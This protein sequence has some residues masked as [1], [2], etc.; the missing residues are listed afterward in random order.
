MSTE[1]TA[2]QAGKTV[3]KSQRVIKNRQEM[4]LEVVKALEQ[5]GIAVDEQEATPKFTCFGELAPEIRS[6]IWQ[7]AMP[8]PRIILIVHDEG[9]RSGVV[10]HEST[11]RRAKAVDASV[12]T[13][14]QVN[15][16]SR[17]EA[18]RAYTLTFGKQLRRGP[19]Y[20][21]FD[22]D[23]LYL[24]TMAD[25]KPCYGGF[26][27]DYRP[28]N[29]NLADMKEDEDNVRF[30]AFGE[31]F[32]SSMICAFSRFSRLE[33]LTLMKVDEKYEIEIPGLTAKC[34]KSNAD[35]FAARRADNAKEKNLPFTVP[36]VEYLPLED[37]AKRNCRYPQPPPDAPLFV[38]RNY[39]HL[40]ARIEAFRY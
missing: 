15:R 38:I 31:F 4:D 3:H 7:E 40:N 37:F 11:H 18:K 1:K 8:G 26:D 30:V 27:R 34:E 2:T 12:P 22:R 23:T 36:N 28:C 21:A 29:T 14:L 16:E 25:L 32:Q 17:R 19:V 39:K 20:F 33:R 24:P 5:L 35:E 6:E 9:S 10:G 13:L